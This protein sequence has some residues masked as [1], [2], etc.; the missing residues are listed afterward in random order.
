M[1]KNLGEQDRLQTT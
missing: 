1:G